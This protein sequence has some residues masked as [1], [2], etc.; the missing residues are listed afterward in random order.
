MNK[1]DIATSFLHLSFS[2][3]VHKANEQFIHSRFRH[4]NAYFNGDL[5]SL[6]KAMEENARQFP[7]KTYVVVIFMM[8]SILRQIREKLR[9][10]NTRAK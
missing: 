4:H 5:E 8:A 9:K 7:D 2:G 3:Q 10:L 6:L 1:M